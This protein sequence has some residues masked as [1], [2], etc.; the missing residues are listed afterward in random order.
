MRRHRSGFKRGV[1]VGPIDWEGELMW[2]G[3][4][5]WQ[6]QEAIQWYAVPGFHKKLL[7]RPGIRKPID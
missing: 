5:Q 4:V 1:D 2:C 6:Q 3:D 7:Y